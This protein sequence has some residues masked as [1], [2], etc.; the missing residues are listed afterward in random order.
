M[1]RGPP[2]PGQ[3]FPKPY[4]DWAA[5]VASGPPAAGNTFAWLF[6]GPLTGHVHFYS[7]IFTVY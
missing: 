3:A 1:V 4:P 2:G 5:S 7:I 6:R